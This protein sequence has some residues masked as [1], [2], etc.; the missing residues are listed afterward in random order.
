M[1]ALAGESVAVSGVC[2]TVVDGRPGG[3]RSTSRRRRSASRPW[4]DSPRGI[5]STSSGRFASTVAL[6]GHLVLGHVD[7]VGEVTRVRP[8]G[9]GARL[10][11]AVP[12]R[13]APAADPQGIGRDRRCE[14]HG[15]GA[16]GGHVRR[17]AHPAHAGGD[18]ARAAAAGRLGQPR[19]GRDRQV[20]ACFVEQWDREKGGW[21]GERADPTA[22]FAAIE[23]AIEEIRQGRMILVVD[24][25]DREN[26]GDLV[27]AADRVTP[28]AINFMAK[29]GRGLICVPLTGERLDDLRIS[30]MVADNTAPMGTAFTVTVDAKRGVT[31]GTSAYDRA[32][33]VR[34]LVD[35][36]HAPRGPGAPG[37][38]PAA[39]LH[40]RR[41]PATRGA[42][43]GRGGPRPVRRLLA[44]RRDLR[45]DGR[46]GG[47]ARA[48]GA[49]RAGGAHGLRMITI[50]DLIRYR[51][52]KDK[53][54]R[55]AATTLLPTATGPSPRSRTRRRWTTAWSS[56]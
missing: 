17:G 37:A 15:R 53:L 39:P 2:L 22:G 21:S 54:V 1:A 8:E 29:H 24:D 50:K 33:T 35:P 4:V 46:A 45:G 16:R 12:P 36:R 44:G 28:E 6:G 47:M 48:P 31:T 30:M 11:V 51:I 19:D 43:G 13:A 25:E 34:A 5:L 26:E 10:D 38:H 32:L 3:S 7:G 27:M 40:V 18:H 41:R 42:H 52:Q 23:A 56:H 55:R 49:L 20:R 14:P 9:E